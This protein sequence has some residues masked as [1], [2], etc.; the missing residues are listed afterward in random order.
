MKTALKLGARFLP[1]DIEGHGVNALDFHIAFYLG[2]F[3]TRDNSAHCIILSKDKGFDPLIK[4]LRGRGLHARRAT[5]MAEAF[6]SKPSA[7]APADT[8][9]KAAK[10]Y[11][12]AIQWLT[13]MSARSRPRKRKGLVAHLHTHFGRNIAEADIQRHVDQMISDKKL[14][15]TN[16][17]LAYHL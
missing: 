13:A 14:S 12:S 8:S 9:G 11:D 10:P 6:P 5:S 7:S 3:L 2:E 17:T 16:G 15:E 4:H 1:I